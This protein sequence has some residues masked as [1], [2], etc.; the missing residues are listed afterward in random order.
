MKGKL[1]GEWKSSCPRRRPIP[2]RNDTLWS[3]CYPINKDLESKTSTGL[4]SKTKQKNFGIKTG[5]EKNSE[6]NIYNTD[7]YGGMTQSKLPNMRRRNRRTSPPSTSHH[8]MRGVKPSGAASFPRNRDAQTYVIPVIYQGL[9]HFDSSRNCDSLPQDHHAHTPKNQ[10]PCTRYDG[11]GE[12]KIPGHMTCVIGDHPAPIGLLDLVKVFSACEGEM[13]H[14]ARMSGT[15]L[16][17]QLRT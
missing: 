12:W 6:C 17:E 16:G 14:Y 13:W 15:D 7:T 5:Q 11:M 2:T 4:A 10:K 9:S 1:G 8:H 3:W